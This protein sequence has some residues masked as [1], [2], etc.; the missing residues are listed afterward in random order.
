MGLR[1]ED[2]LQ[3]WR[4]PRWP[5]F[6]AGPGEPHAYMVYVGAGWA[7]ARLG[8]RPAR[9]PSTADPLLR[10][11]IIDGFG[12]HE[13]YFHAT[14]VIERQ[15][16]PPAVSGYARRAFDQGLGRS[17]WFVEGSAVDGI[18]STLSRFAESR[19]ADL[20]S[21]VGLAAAY[22]GGVEPAAYIRLRERAGAHAPG[23]AQ[24]AAFAAKARLRAGLG[25]AHT[26]CAC[27]I[28]CGMSAIEAAA[29]TDQALEQL[30]DGDAANPAYDH[31]RRRIRAHFSLE[32][33]AA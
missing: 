14:R 10:W 5:A 26:E 16:V 8:G 20:W 17:L 11:L 33:A 6:L 31:W 4:R 19:H 32:R 24:G 30:P 29:V 25:A 12:F 27:E 3:P 7:M 23:V 1:L 22:A 21:G 18:S 28:L 9:F 15:I 2:V 13:G